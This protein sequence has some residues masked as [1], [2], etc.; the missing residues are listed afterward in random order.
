MG[1]RGGSRVLRVDVLSRPY[2]APTPLRVGVI[3]NSVDALTL[4]RAGG[5]VHIAEIAKRWPNVTL[6]VMG[7]ANAEHLIR[8]SMRVDAFISVPAFG[9]GI[10]AG[11]MLMRA[12]A[13]IIA[14][15]RMRHEC[16]VVMA[17]SHSVPDVLPAVVFGRRKAAVLLWHFIGNPFTREGSPLRNSLAFANEL[18]G[19][20]LASLCRGRILGSPAVARELKLVNRP[21][22]W[23]TTNGVEECLPAR[24]SN[25]SGSIF[26]GRLH[27]A[28]G[29]DDLIRAWALVHERLPS[30]RLTIVGRG[31]PAYR[32]HLDQTIE[33]LHLRDVVEIRDNVENDEKLRLL[34][35]S[36]LFVF[37]SKEEGWGIAIA[38]AMAFGLPCVTYELP[39][40][41]DIFPRGRLHVAIGDVGAFAGAV[42]RALSD[43]SL[44]DSLGAEAFEQAKAFRWSI[45]AEVELRALHEIAR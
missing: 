17:M 22:T 35:R 45:A 12:L 1:A 42:V 19:R 43:S 11:S 30:E 33:Q 14:V 24:S 3:L 23:V 16:D 44:R 4:D 27:P 25:P 32:A 6:S 26:V 21:Y 20:A 36:Q 40:F 13:A 37:P 10:S 29:L 7:P 39:P 38:E 28:K 5:F 2:N 18:V 9:G 15:P 8:K 34:A 41:A 31:M